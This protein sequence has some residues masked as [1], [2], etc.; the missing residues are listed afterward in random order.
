[1]KLDDLPKQYDNIVQAVDITHDFAV[2]SVLLSILESVSG[3]ERRHTLELGQWD[4]RK[5]CNEIVQLK[6]FLTTCQTKRVREQVQAR[7]NSIKADSQERIDEERFLLAQQEDSISAYEKY[8]NISENESRKQVSQDRIDQLVKIAAEDAWKS[9]V[10]TDTIEAYEKYLDL[11]KEEALVDHHDEA[12][13]RLKTLKQN[14]LDRLWTEAQEQEHV[15]AYAEL[16]GKLTLWEVDLGNAFSRWVSLLKKMGI[17]PKDEFWIAAVV[18]FEEWQRATQNPSLKAFQDYVGGPEKR[19]IYRFRK[20]AE[21]EIERYIRDLE[22]LSEIGVEVDASNTF[23]RNLNVVGDNAEEKLAKYLEQSTDRLWEEE[24]R[25]YIQYESR[26]ERESREHREN[27]DEA[28]W[29]KATESET[30]IGYLDYLC[31]SPLFDIRK[32]AL[33]KLAALL[34]PIELKVGADFSFSLGTVQYEFKWIPKPNED[35][36]W[37]DKV[38]QGFWILQEPLKSDQVKIGTDRIL[39][40]HERKLKKWKFCFLWNQFFREILS[41]FVQS[42]LKYAPEIPGEDQWEYALS[43]G[44]RDRFWEDEYRDHV[45]ERGREVFYPIEI[46]TPANKWS[47][48]PAFTRVRTMRGAGVYRAEPE[49][50]GPNNIHLRLYELKFTDGKIEQSLL[51]KSAS[52]DCW[53]SKVAVKRWQKD[54]ELGLCVYAWEFL[55]EAKSDSC[56]YRPVIIQL[57]S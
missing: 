45:Y 43:E 26:K 12:C 5:K 30:I 9:V 53:M 56:K 14:E 15:T 18:D 49:V 7:I 41:C 27:E 1:M 46:L 44:K 48:K 37:S 20:R 11:S 32:R 10:K 28:L 13:S 52:D 31:Q 23:G 36:Q 2:I 34:D 38:K 51:K 29:I 21:T 8:I 33:P 24:L 54:R 35:A 4:E 57:E 6:G 55:V 47:L 50:V 17:T 25:W 16:I 40:S 19:H 39:L 3:K 42:D 22:V